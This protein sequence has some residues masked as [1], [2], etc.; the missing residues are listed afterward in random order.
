MNISTIEF[1]ESTDKSHIFDNFILFLIKDELLKN[2]T[3]RIPF[4]MK[5]W[6]VWEA[7]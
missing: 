4:Q 5:K 7:Y 2:D 1:V 6:G 3:K